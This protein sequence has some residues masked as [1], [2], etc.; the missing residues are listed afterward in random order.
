MICKPRV[1]FFRINH[2]E[3]LHTCVNKKKK[4]TVDKNDSD[5]ITGEALISNLFIFCGF[6]LKYLQLK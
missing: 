3:L 2:F 6:H 5:T 4:K 1:F